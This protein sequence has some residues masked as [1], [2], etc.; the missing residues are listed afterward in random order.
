MIQGSCEIFIKFVY[1]AL[2]VALHSLCWR[3]GLQEQGADGSSG[4]AARNAATV[5]MTP[6]TPQDGSP[7]VRMFQ[8]DKLRDRLQR[9]GAALTE[10]LTAEESILFCAV[11]DKSGDDAVRELEQVHGTLR[12]QLDA[13]VQLANDIY[14][15]RR[16][17]QDLRKK[18]K[19]LNQLTRASGAADSSSLS[20]SSPS[21]ASSRSV[22]DV[23]S[24]RRLLRSKSAAHGGRPSSA[25]ET[26]AAAALGSSPPSSSKKRL[27]RAV[28]TTPPSSAS[29][30]VPI[31]LVHGGIS[32]SKG[33]DVGGRRA[34]KLS[35]ASASSIASPAALSPSDSD[36]AAIE[37][38]LLLR[39]D[40]ARLEHTVYRLKQSGKSLY[41]MRQRLMEDFV[42]FRATLIAL[43]REQE[44]RFCGVLSAH[45]DA[46][47]QVILLRKLMSIS[48]MSGMT[49][50]V[51]WV[52][53]HLSRL[54]D[55][56][57][58]LLLLKATMPFRFVDVCHWIRTAIP[59]SRFVKWKSEIN[60]EL[61]DSHCAPDDAEPLEFVTLCHEAI[62]RGLVSLEHDLSQVPFVW[63]SIHQSMTVLRFM[64]VQAMQKDLCLFPRLHEK[65]EQVFGVSA[66]ADNIDDDAV[67]QCV[68][69]LSI[70]S[71]YMIAH[72][73]HL[74]LVRQVHQRISEFQRHPNEDFAN[75]REAVRDVAL[76]TREQMEREEEH[77]MA[78]AYLLLTSNEQASIVRSMLDV[79]PALYHAQMMPWLFSELDDEQ[80][81]AFVRCLGWALPT[82]QLASSIEL[83]R[84]ALPSRRWGVLDAGLS[85]VQ[86]WRDAVDS[87]NK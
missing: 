4:A 72:Q 64:S 36:S 63:S 24:S 45:Y 28:S 74:A 44:K 78:V 46:D 48:S 60:V 77:L 29:A 71:S 12:A 11:S 8:I 59:P 3:L 37:E 47:A 33:S 10:Y 13:L 70:G 25:A 9:F 85:D 40:M 57:G 49:A 69:L 32:R 62:D 38:M 42:E 81:H 35:S 82:D 52:V 76:L 39:A 30:T 51:P 56:R 21:K 58:L 17:K 54:D 1:Q 67:R 20:H 15:W 43:L 73:R 31:D 84:S 86:A 6:R 55:Q 61:H 41:D 50:L 7:D 23:S 2:G 65:I 16:L 68:P 83:L 22:T 66:A 18:S 14:E 19:R 53:A 87:L 75:I 34:R 80:R 79:A 5:L 27:S 26:V